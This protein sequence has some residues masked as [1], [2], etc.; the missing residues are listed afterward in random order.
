[1]TAT[2]DYIN[3][4]GFSSFMIHHS[5]ELFFGIYMLSNLLVE[6]INVGSTSAEKI[7][8][9]WY[10]DIETATPSTQNKIN[11]TIR[12]EFK[13]YAISTI[14]IIT[15]CFFNLVLE[16]FTDIHFTCDIDLIGKWFAGYQNLKFLLTCFSL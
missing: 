10:W 13:T 12:K 3:N 2:I 11:E 5:L 7:Q 1:M 6:Y 14:T 16:M 15:I 8:L 4:E 9:E